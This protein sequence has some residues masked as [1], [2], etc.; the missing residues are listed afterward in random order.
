MNAFS[1]LKA[2]GR[3]FCAYTAAAVLSVILPCAGGGVA[4]QA[5][6]QPGN[7]RRPLAAERS[8][9]KEPECGVRGGVRAACAQGHRIP[10]REL[11]LFHVPAERRQLRGQHQVRRGRPIRWR[12][13]FRLRRRMRLLRKSLD[14]VYKKMGSDDGV[15]VEQADKFHYKITFKN[16]TVEFELPDLSNLKPAAGML[17]DDEVYLRAVLGRI[18]RSVLPG[19]QQDGEGIPLSAQRDAQS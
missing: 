8:R 9:R 6:H 10:H 4:P 18:R 12:S 15:K 16:K 5:A 13:A 17:R 11:L 7:H 19:F 2:L 3:P 14:P 1:S